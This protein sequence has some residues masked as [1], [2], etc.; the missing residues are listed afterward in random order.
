MPYVY[1]QA[2]LASQNGHPFLRTLFFE[3]PEDP[4]SWFVEDQYLFGTYI[5]VAPLMEDNPGRNVYLPPGH[6]TDPDHQ[7]L[8]QRRVAAHHRRRSTR[9]YAREGRRG[10]TA[11]QARPEYRPHGLG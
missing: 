11:R 9:G 3:Y 4:T 7:D 1:A 8:R 2:K 5:L 10:D 6:W